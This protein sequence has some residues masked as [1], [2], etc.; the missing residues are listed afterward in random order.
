MNSKLKRNTL[1]IGD[2]GISYLCG[3]NKLGRPNFHLLHATGFNANTYRQILEPLSAY[4]NVYACDLRGHGLGTTQANPAEL[5]SW[6][7]YREDFCRFLEAINEPM[8]LMGHSVGSVVSIAGAVKHPELIKGLILTE[9]LLYPHGFDQKNVET[10]PLASGARR[11]RAEFPSRQAMVNNYVG[12]GAFKTWERSWIE[13]Y[14]S[15]GSLEKADGS[16]VL[17]CNPEWEAVS[18][19]VAELTPWADVEKLKCP[20][21]IVYANGGAFSTCYEDGVNKFLKIRPHTGIITCL[22]ASHFLPMEK[23]DLVIEAVLALVAQVE[24][25]KP[26]VL[27]NR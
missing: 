9:P 3:E 2:G 4:L 17:S 23:P 24:N 11:R 27:G 10:N 7:V 22:D 1:E 8:Y 19:Q 15:G 18:F 14:V 21:T 13:D 26:K 16:V 5:K 12:K 20:S 6:D 25:K